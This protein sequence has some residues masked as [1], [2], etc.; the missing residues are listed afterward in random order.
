MNKFFM[1]YGALLFVF[2]VIFV[3]GLEVL[4][5]PHL[6][7]LPLFLVVLGAILLLLR[8]R[9]SEKGPSTSND[10]RGQQKNL[11]T[12]EA[13]TSLMNAVWR[14]SLVT[15][16]T[17]G[18]SQRFLNG[19][20]GLM[21]PLEVPVR[22]TNIYVLKQNDIA[23]PRTRY[24]RRPIILLSDRRLF[25][26]MPI[27]GASSAETLVPGYS[28]LDFPRADVKVSDFHKDWYTILLSPSASISVK[29]DP[30]IAPFIRRKSIA[31]YRYLS[32]WMLA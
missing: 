10:V 9:G 25:L 21:S 4:L 16:P 26:L 22:I 14:Q 30:L 29:V 3:L 6:Q 31:F 2:V 7:S 11:N 32:T 27:Q 19:L 13:S 12:S 18:P 20:S 28:H 1:K 24:A 15:P 8:L 23:Y 17:V 5:P